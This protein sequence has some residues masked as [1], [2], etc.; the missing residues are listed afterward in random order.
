MVT[1]VARSAPAMSGDNHRSE[2]STPSS[3]GPSAELNLTGT[4]TPTPSL[5]NRVTPEYN[6]VLDFASLANLNTAL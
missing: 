6:R 1:S 2:V 4:H 3:T 5:Q